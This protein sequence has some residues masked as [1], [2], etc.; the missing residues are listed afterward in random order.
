MS[1]PTSIICL[2]EETVETLYL[3][4]KEDL[5]LGVSEYMQ[6]PA[7][8][9]G[10]HPVVSQFLRS[11]YD[12]IVALRPDLVIGFSD[13][14]KK[15]A[16]E[17][18]ARGVN[19]YISNQRSIEEIFDQIIFLGKLVNKGSE[20]LELVKTFRAKIQEIKNLVKNEKKVKVYFEEWDHPRLS[21]IRWVSELI[22]ICGGENSFSEKNGKS[23]SEREVNDEEIIRKNPDV[24]I[25]CWCGKKVDIEKIKNRSG[26]S[27]INAV[28]NDQ[29]YEVD[30]AVFLQ[31]G[32]ALFVDGLSQLIEIFNKMRSNS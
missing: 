23:A 31:P 29:V 7:K 10:K 13:V 27:N 20:A 28:R 17:L 16:H 32:P 12:E 11:N 24:I 18:V 30:P 19:V 8:A 6:R 3:L 26:Y 4:G 22:E 2:T 9:V 15:V 21:A 5:I 1:F 25:G 14:Q